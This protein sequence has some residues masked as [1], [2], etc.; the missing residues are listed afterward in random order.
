MNG[1]NLC[2]LTVEEIFNLIRDDGYS[3]DHSLK[4]S[5]A[6]YKKGIRSFSSVNGIPKKLKVHLDETCSAGIISPDSCEISSDGTIK[7]LFTSAR[8]QKD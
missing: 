3:Y 8:K 6:I 5:N 2:G 4:I 1:N 7:Y